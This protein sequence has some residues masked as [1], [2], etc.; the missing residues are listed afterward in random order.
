MSN[1]HTIAGLATQ[2]DPPTDR[3]SGPV[4]ERIAP[5]LQI[6]LILAEYGRHLATTI[7]HRALRRGFATIAQFFGTATLAVIL[8]R[9]HRGIMRAMALERVLLERASRGRD[10]VVPAPR[11]RA[12]LAAEPPV[13]LDAAAQP[14]HAAAGQPESAAGAQ[15][16][17]P[18]ALESAAAAQSA[19]APAAPPPRVRR[20][21]EEE[22]LTFDNMPSM[23]EIEKEVRRRP[24]GRTVAD[25]CR[26]LGISPAL[27]LGPFWTMLFDA[28]HF[29]RGSVGNLRARHAAAGEAARPRGLEAPEPRLPGGNEGGDPARAGVPHR[30]AAGQSV[31]PSA[32]GESVSCGGC[33]ARSG[34][35]RRDR[36][37]VNATQGPPTPDERGQSMAGPAVL[38]RAVARVGIAPG[39]AALWTSWSCGRPGRTCEHAGHAIAQV[40]HAISARW[41]AQ[42]WLS[43]VARNSDVA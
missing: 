8:P 6:A 38:I 16:E 28:I 1:A 10:L 29:Y 37:A 3:D 32:G 25:I 21:V 35:G 22:P 41:M 15:P 24:F 30:R 12:S 20:T 43:P 26:D 4:P 14:E 11:A 42:V 2:P 13:A 17:P 36:T 7:Q 5:I 19:G 31:P 40:G 34:A 23:A 33:N 9:I 39:R 27:C 18:A